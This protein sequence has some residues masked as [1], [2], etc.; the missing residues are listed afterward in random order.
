MS[1]ILNKIKIGVAI[2]VGLFIFLTLVLKLSPDSLSSQRNLT[3][4]EG[5]LK[6]TWDRYDIPEG[7]FCSVYPEREDAVV[8]IRPNGD[9]LLAHQMSFNGVASFV[10]NGEPVTRINMR[11]KYLLYKGEGPS[12]G[13]PYKVI[14]DR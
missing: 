4:R 13:A 10:A 7:K 8:T 9:E 6:D 1:P 5:V 3:T 14:C 11:V 2:M 12:V